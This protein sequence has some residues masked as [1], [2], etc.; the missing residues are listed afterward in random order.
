M[1]DEINKYKLKI[2]KYL[3]KIENYREKIDD[4]ECDI[5]FIKYYFREFI[6]PKFIPNYN[7]KIKTGYYIK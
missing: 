6:F 5:L 1:N 4:I 2:K 7:K 3:K